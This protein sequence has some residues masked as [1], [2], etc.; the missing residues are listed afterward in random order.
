LNAH[1]SEDHSPN[2]IS[3]Y[4]SPDSLGAIPSWIHTRKPNKLY[5][6]GG[7]ASLALPGP[8]VSMEAG[9]L[10]EKWYTPLSNNNVTGDWLISG[11]MNFPAD[12]AIAVS[13]AQYLY[14]VS[15]TTGEVEKVASLPPG[16][17]SPW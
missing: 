9:S 16:S 11:A 15:A 7:G 13:Q 4:Q 6:S 5:V 10:R 1:T 17:N 3:A 12:G 14:K 8:F 2:P